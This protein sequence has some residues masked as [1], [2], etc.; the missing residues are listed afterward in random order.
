MR[1]LDEQVA[2]P[3]PL[4]VAP[5]RKDV[6]GETLGLP[7]DERLEGTLALVV[8]SAAGGASIVRVHDVR[9][10]VRTVTM[11]EAVMGRGKPASPVRGLWD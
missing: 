2:Q 10:A 6:V 7:L 4:L 11:T 9:A 3:W 8:L 5:S 1:R